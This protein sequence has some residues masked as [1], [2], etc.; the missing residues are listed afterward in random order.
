A[1]LL[2]LA[3][4]ANREFEFPRFIHT[5]VLPM[6]IMSAFYVLATFVVR[7]S[8]LVPT[9]IGFLDSMGRTLYSSIHNLY[10]F[11]T[12]FD[13]FP[14]Q[15]PVGIYWMALC[16]IPLARK[17]VRLSW[18]QWLLVLFAFFSART[19]T[20]M[21]GLFVG[22]VCFRGN[23]RKSL[24][25]GVLLIIGLIGVYVVD[26]A[27]GSPMRVASTVDQFTSLE[28]A[29][30]NE[31][32]AEFGSGRMAQII[33][34]WELMGDLHRYWLG[35]GFLHPQLTTNPKFQIKNEYY[36]DV[37]KS[38]EVATQVEVTQFQ[39]ILDCGFLGLIIQTAAYV[40]I[41]FMIRRLR[42]S[43]Y[44]LCVLVAISVFGIGG[45]AGLTQRDGLILLATTLGAVL[46][47]NPEGRAVPQENYYKEDAA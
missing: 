28:A 47:A 42:Y 6:L 29:A 22:F 33:P 31:D 13:F 34:K 26:S 46:L 24:I 1:F 18:K 43:E 12:R 20:F 4:F 9:G 27:L 37:S 30:D 23:M 7:G 17:Q 10:W 35:L 25:A 41:Y 15:Y 16:I 14:R 3:V 45:F 32:L 5:V 8:E 11:P 44:Y 38:E 40:A 21:A 39:T 19:M 36:V 2:P